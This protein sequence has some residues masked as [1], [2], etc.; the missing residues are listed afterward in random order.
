MISVKSST[1]NIKTVSFDD[2]NKIAEQLMT[3]KNSD[4]L[5]LLEQCCFILFEKKDERFLLSVISNVP[6]VNKYLLT[7]T[8]DGSLPIMRNIDL[9]QNK[10][11][12]SV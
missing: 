4:E 10:I 3:T 8:S 5:T 6:N 9:F 12:D 7:K 2:T 1:S 11:Y